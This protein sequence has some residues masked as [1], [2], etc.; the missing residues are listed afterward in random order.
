MDTQMQVE[1]KVRFNE[2]G[3]QVFEVSNRSDMTPEE[4]AASNFTSEEYF[5][6][7][8][9]EK[10]LTWYISQTGTVL[11]IGEDDLGLE[12]KAD[13]VQRRQR[14]VESCMS[15]LLEQELQKETTGFNPEG[16]AEACS[17]FSSESAILAYNRAY[18]NAIQV[19]SHNCDNRGEVSTRFDQI[20]GCP[21]S[22]TSTIDDVTLNY[23]DLYSATS[24][25]QSDPFALNPMPITECTPPRQFHAYI[26]PFHPKPEP[27][28]HQS[29]AREYRHEYYHPL[30]HPW[31]QWAHHIS[32]K[33]RCQRSQSMHWYIAE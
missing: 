7:K 19:Q 10:Q 30:P 5:E 18:S 13:K 2:S 32:E 9:R 17:E 29:D 25:K 22:P 28:C 1:K 14:R 8:K 20:L 33:E 4:Y 15:V 23:L 16:L 24:A 31:E 12:S 21:S 6:I 3:D 11:E 26:P 27:P